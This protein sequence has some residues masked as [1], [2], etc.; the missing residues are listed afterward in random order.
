MEETYKFVDMTPIKS[1]DYSFRVVEY[2]QD[3]VVERDLL[4]NESL[5]L[6][7]RN[8]KYNHD[9][10]IVYPDTEGADYDLSLVEEDLNYSVEIYMVYNDEILR[11]G[12]KVDNW[13][14]SLEVI[15]SSNH[16]AFKIITKKPYPVIAQDFIELWDGYMIGKASEHLPELELR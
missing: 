2:L 4:E 13:N 7:L 10:T 15:G 14:P 6:T 11:G 16:I 12:Y 1:F 9:L 8:H 5:I 3:N